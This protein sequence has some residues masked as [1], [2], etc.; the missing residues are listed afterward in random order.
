MNRRIFILLLPSLF[1]SGC[2]SIYYAAMEK[3]GREKRDIL[4]K[5]ILTVKKDQQQTGKQLKSTLEVFKEVTGF[6]GGDLEKTYNRLHDSLDH[7]QDRAKELHNHV[8][9]VDDVA[10]R[11]FS[12]WK[13][14]I[15][16]MRNVTLKRQSQTLLTN[17]QRQHSGYMR[18]MRATEAKI[19]PVLQGF[20]DQVVFLKHNLNARAISSLKKTSADLDLQANDLVREINDSSKEADQYINTLAQADAVAK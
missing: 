17:A 6:E 4:V 18:Q 9:S 16:D 5:R 8:N 20:N 2:N 14:E 15:N 12:E 7:C 11:M 1:I 10:K 13:G 3:L 19:T